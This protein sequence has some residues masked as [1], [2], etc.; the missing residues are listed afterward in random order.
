MA[1]SV[2]LRRP[3][4]RS[5]TDFADS[6]TPPGPSALGLEPCLEAGGLNVAGVLSPQ[7]YDSLVPVGWRSTLLLPSARHV[8]VLGSGGPEFFHAAMAES[9]PGAPHPLDQFAENL[10][11]RAA[12]HLR[13]AG[14]ATRT[15]YYYERRRANAAAEKA[16]FADFVALARACGLGAGSR[17]GLLLHPRF[18]PWFAIRALIM[19]EFALDSPASD[20]PACSDPCD[21]CAAPCAST[22]HGAALAGQ[23]FDVARCSEARRSNAACLDRCDARLACRL[24]RDYAHDPVELAYHMGASFRGMCEP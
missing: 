11:E 1:K 3:G 5:V 10:V 21:G 15:L 20:W 24:G 16:D 23:S 8:V 17:L 22:C 2:S 13:G 9:A 4:S 19:T 7:R 6:P 12:D 14:A 18:G